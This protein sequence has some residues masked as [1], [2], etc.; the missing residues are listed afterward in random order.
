MKITFPEPINQANWFSIP[1]SNQLV[2]VGANG[3]GKTKIGTWFE[4][5]LGNTHRVSAQKS[6][7]MPEK[8]NPTSLEEA[9][10]AF[11]IGNVN[12]T[13]M[14]QR[15]YYRW[16]NKPDNYLLGDFPALM[17][18][19]QT[20]EYE[21]LIKYKKTVNDGE[22]AQMPKTN[23][24]K[25]KDAWEE[26]LP[27]RELIISAGK[28]NTKIPGTEIVYNASGMSD[29]ERVIFYLLGE[30]LCAP[31]DAYVIFDEPEM[32]IHK[33]LVGT[34]WNKA[35][36]LRPDCTFIY[37]TH[38]LDF[39]ASR[40]LADKIWLRDF[41][42]SK[43]DYV[44]INDFEESIPD[45]LYL[46]VLGSRKKILFI[47]GDSS[48]LDSFIYESIF[49]EYTVKPLGS[50]QKVINCTKSFNSLSSFHHIESNG[51]VDRD[52][53]T[54]EEIASLKASAIM[55]PEVAEIENFFLLENA[56]KA[57][58]RDMHKN[59]DD[60]FEAVKEKVF[61]FFKAQ[62]ENQVSL[63]STS[64]INRVIARSISVSESTQESVQEE[65]NTMTASI[66]VEAIFEKYRTSFCE[67]LES[68]DYIGIL[69]VFNNKGLIFQSQV[70]NLCDI[71]PN[72]YTAYVKGL[73]KRR[74]EIGQNICQTIRDSILL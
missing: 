54:E 44:H 50:C 70:A 74:Q 34:F 1:N 15:S 4:L 42:G 47:E 55:V 31:P 62:L 20:E 73:I 49:P 51:L 35:E 69:R 25:I 29:G 39:A 48:S 17:V 45:D 57:V 12:S 58:A 65:Y 72:N 3:S 67:I 19:L 40:H 41:D 61:A 28:I 6:L 32:H 63:H 24:D 10:R 38:D 68:E 14:S 22:D 56:V 26:I 33:S 9:Q 37:L 59:E 30:I 5:N 11:L 66:D 13:E 52:R 7:T 53:R 21:S 18:L 43:W 36:T 71:I 2:V 8:V 16:G 27:Q 60:V 64:E 46:E 23:L